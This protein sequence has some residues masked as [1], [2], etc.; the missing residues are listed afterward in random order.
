MSWETWGLGVYRVPGML[1]GIRVPSELPR[2]L[3]YFLEPPLGVL[4]SPV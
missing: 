2:C 1:P 4:G 3:R